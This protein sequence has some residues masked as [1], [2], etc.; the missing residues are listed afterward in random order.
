MATSLL[1]ERRAGHEAK[2]SN[3]ELFFDLVYVFA[4]TQLSHHLLGHLTLL[5]AVQTLLLW[6]AVWLGWQYTCWITNWFDPEKL[7]IR[8]L[9]FALMLL[10]LPMAAAIPEAFGPRGPMF[11]MCFASIQVGR[12]LFVLLSLGRRSP[13]AP[14]FRRILGWTLISACFWIAGAL[15][16]DASSRMAL[17]A[18][19]VACEYFSPMF[20]FALPLLGRSTSREWTIEGGHLAERCQLCM[21]VALGES[22]LVT[23][24]TFSESAQWGGAIAWAFGFAFAIS[25][26]LWWIYFDTSSADASHR[27]AH[28]AD[29]GGMGAVFHYLHVIIVGSVIVVAVGCEL[30]IAHPHQAA[31][32]SALAAL[33]GGPALYLVGNAFFRRVVYGALPLSHGAGLL[34][35]GLCATAAAVL[36]LDLLSLGAAVTGLLLIVATWDGCTQRHRVD[37]P[38]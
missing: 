3:A 4:V 26:A 28:A 16:D 14:N 38:R 18:V 32:T 7:P 9:L 33:A 21:I 31:T 6:F 29:P 37:L 35:L 11:A 15:Q 36:G 5:G 13:L 30:L 12:T 34:G 23:G 27:I 20:G 8:L 25:L 19:A 22:I 1:R 24:A 2:V 10:A 17:W